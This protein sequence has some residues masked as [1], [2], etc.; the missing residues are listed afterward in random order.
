MINFKATAVVTGFGLAL[1]LGAAGAQAG[2]LPVLNG[3]FNSTT[4]N[5]GPNQ[6]G[7]QNNTTGQLDGGGSTSNGYLTATSWTNANFS[8]S[9]AGYN[10]IFNSAGTGPSSQNSITNPNLALYSTLTSTNA[11]LQISPG[12]MA[13]PNNPNG[14]FLGGDGAQKYQ[15]AAVSQ[16]IGGL[17]SGTPYTLTFDQ[18]FA[19]QTQAS[20]ASG[21]PANTISWWLIGLGGTYFDTW[22]DINGAFA[23]CAATSTGICQDN[24]ITPG[25]ELHAGAGAFSGWFLN[26][27]L[28][29][30]PN[31]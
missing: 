31:A 5:T 10:F 14:N 18:A 19:E 28:T 30:T 20:G 15:P 29:F 23:S 26:G 27:S 24:T 16:T 12:N 7:P 21:A 17:T 8:G 3:F 11:G 9:T 13:D 22:V 6:S 4:S 1:S 25:Y 2:S